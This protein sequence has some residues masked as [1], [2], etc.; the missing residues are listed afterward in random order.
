MHGTEKQAG[1]EQ[2]ASSSEGRGGSNERV[3][4]STTRELQEAPPLPR[5]RGSPLPVLPQGQNSHPTSVLA[6][7]PQ[8]PAPHLPLSLV[9]VP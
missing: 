2:M 1:L 7:G 6:M 3:R 8:S 4:L 5:Q 9:C